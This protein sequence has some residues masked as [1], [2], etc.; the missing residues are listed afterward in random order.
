MPRI[1]PGRVAA[2]LLFLA[3]LPGLLDDLLGWRD[4]F[5]AIGGTLGEWIIPAA[6][7]AAALVLLA[8]KP[9]KSWLPNRAKRDDEL[10]AVFETGAR[11]A[12]E[13]ARRLLEMAARELLVVRSDSLRRDVAVLFQ[14]T[15]DDSARAY[16]LAANAIVH[17]DGTGQEQAL[18][19]LYREYQGVSS[20]L[21]RGFEHGVLN[22]N[23]FL[24]REWLAADTRF[25][26]QLRQLTSQRDREILRSEVHAVGWGEGVRR[27]LPESK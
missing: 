18:G 24:Y 20:R 22:P 17:L 25:L 12:L 14:R 2:L 3:G 26:D 7:V 10:Y 9:V 21:L 23:H 8:Y 19:L 6:L 1:T 15:L 16:S 11:P 5:G 4:W 13:L 27:V